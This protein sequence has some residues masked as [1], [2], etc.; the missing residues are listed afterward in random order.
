MP[1][2]IHLQLSSRL[3]TLPFD[4][5][6][7]S[8]SYA[9]LPCSPV[10]NLLVWKETLFFYDNV[11]SKF[12]WWTCSKVLVRYAR[13]W[14]GPDACFRRSVWCAVRCN[15]GPGTEQRTWYS[16]QK[17][18][19]LHFSEVL[20]MTSSL[21]MCWHGITCF[22][23]WEWIVTG[24]LPLVKYSP[25]EGIMTLSPLCLM[26]WIHQQLIWGLNALKTLTDGYLHFLGQFFIML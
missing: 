13:S 25:S 5:I 21:F 17:S 3:D 4:F 16:S 22:W 11:N 6:F 23:E 2:F 12:S 19:L 8:N 15:S 9:L 1:V 26:Q 10:F 14:S 18:G 24:V 7:L 20:S